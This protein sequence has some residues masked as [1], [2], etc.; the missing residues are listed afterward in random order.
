MKETLLRPRCRWEKNIRM[1]SQKSVGGMDWIDLG[2]DK[3]QWQVTLA[4]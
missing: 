2:Q 3:D 4:R 1:D